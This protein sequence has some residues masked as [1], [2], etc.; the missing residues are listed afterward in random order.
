LRAAIGHPAGI[1]TTTTRAPGHD[2]RAHPPG[3]GSEADVVT[4]MPFD[5]LFEQAPPSVALLV[6]LG[7]PAGAQ[8]ALIRFPT[9]QWPV[10]DPRLEGYRAV[11]VLSL[12][13][14]AAG[15]LPEAWAPGFEPHR[16][17]LV[18]VRY[19]DHRVYVEWRF[20]PAEGPYLQTR[21]PYVWEG[22]LL[23]PTTAEADRAAFGETL[24]RDVIERHKPGRMPDKDWWP[25]VASDH[26]AEIWEALLTLGRRDRRLMTQEQ[27]AE[28]LKRDPSTLRKWL[29]PGRWK[30]LK[31]AAYHVVFPR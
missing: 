25:T 7:V 10:Y 30:A 27:V 3:Q 2:P 12:D 24:L 6:E 26:E 21:H 11:F 28:Y 14:D 13:P 29:G 1:T 8:V 23:V 18:R 31:Q 5:P 16:P 9:E 15:Q 20:S 19:G 22:Q 4:A 17:R